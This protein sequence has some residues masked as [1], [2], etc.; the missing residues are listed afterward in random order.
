MGNKSSSIDKRS[1]DSASET[2][3]IKVYAYLHFIC[4]PDTPVRDNRFFI[5][6]N[7][8]DFVENI[9]V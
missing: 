8:M 4:T 2:N 5:L 6:L 3:K 7:R 9:R 1:Q